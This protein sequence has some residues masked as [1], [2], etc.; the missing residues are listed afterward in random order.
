MSSREI[1]PSNPV[2][3]D[4][5]NGPLKLVPARRR[6]LGERPPIM[7]PAHKIRS[8]RATLSSIKSFSPFY[9]LVLHAP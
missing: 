1:V 7:G 3:S 6:L 9:R 8:V 5:F 2:R 4:W